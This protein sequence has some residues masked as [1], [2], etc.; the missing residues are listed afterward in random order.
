MAFKMK[1]FSGFN[2]SP[3]KKDGKDKRVLR[4]ANRKIIRELRQKVKDGEMSREKFKSAK[5]E[6]KNYTDVDVA[7]EYLENLN[8]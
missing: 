6:I 1:G 4:K 3:L 8:K 7:R 5:E 2:N